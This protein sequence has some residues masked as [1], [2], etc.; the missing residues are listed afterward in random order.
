MNKM[1]EWYNRLEFWLKV[2]EMLNCKSR[3]NLNDGKVINYCADEQRDDD[4]DDDGVN[5]NWNEDV[6]SE[7]VMTP[8]A[9]EDGD[10]VEVKLTASLL[11]L[12][13]AMKN[14]VKLMMIG[15]WVKQYVDKLGNPFI[16]N[17]L[18]FKHK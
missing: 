11:W 17:Y 6:D 10:E 9:G 15:N 12:L 2:K 13:V 16:T 14:M 3:V 7:G 8:F 5:L 1:I 4:G 18:S